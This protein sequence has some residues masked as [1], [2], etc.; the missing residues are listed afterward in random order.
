MDEEQYIMEVRLDGELPEDLYVSQLPSITMLKDYPMRFEKP[1]TFFVGEN[2]SGKSTLLEA[3]AVKYG[4]NPEGGTRD[5]SFETAN[6][7][8][9]LYKYI[10]LA[11]KY[12]PRDGFFL[13]S[14]SF[15]NFATDVDE[16]RSDDVLAYRS[17][18]EKSLHKRSH[19]ESIAAVIQN[20]FFGN[21]LYILDEP[22][23]ALSV[24]KQYM[25]ISKIY[26]LVKERSQFIIATHSPI[27]T[28]YPN[29]NI[30]EFSEYGIEKTEY[31]NTD[32]YRLTKQFINNREK[33][34]EILLS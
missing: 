10:T 17:Y 7:H 23:A 4:F 27:L 5:Y 11:K 19:G 21:G 2:G 33:I 22:E 31:E 15:Y 1:V 9:G 30:Y 16:R 14:E 29:A 18:G 34:C 28:G 6:T 26:Q 24:S 32:N 8:S 25:L 12:R 20:R 3:I 13:R